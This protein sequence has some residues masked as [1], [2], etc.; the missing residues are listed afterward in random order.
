MNPVQVLA[1][2]PPTTT[3]TTD[4]PRP[5]HNLPASPE[6]RSPHAAH[7]TTNGAN[8][9]NGTHSHGSPGSP[10]V[11]KDTNSSTSTTATTA[12]MATGASNETVPSVYSSLSSPPSFVTHP[13][14]S[15]KEGIDSVANRRASRR[16]TGPLSAIQR[17]RAALIRKLGACTDCRRRRVA[18]SLP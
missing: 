18:V 5:G 9:T 4:E 6:P 3:T 10:P 16:R 13:A 17:E 1:E 8:G 14:F 15:V 7:A 2:A 12:T 11:R